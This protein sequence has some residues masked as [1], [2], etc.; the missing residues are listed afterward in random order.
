MICNQTDILTNGLSRNWIKQLQDHFEPARAIHLTILTV[1]CHKFGPIQ[2][3]DESISKR[4]M[5][6]ISTR[7][8]RPPHQGKKPKEQKTLGKYL[9]FFLIERYRIMNNYFYLI[10]QIYLQTRWPWT[11]Y[12]TCMT[13]N[14]T[15]KE[16]ESGTRKFHLRGETRMK[17]EGKKIGRFYES[18]LILRHMKISLFNKNIYKINEICMWN[19]LIFRA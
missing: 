9:F 4:G 11:P 1:D 6:V 15:T 19:F 3:S 14:E 18:K 10:T 12:V 7:I 16:K 5:D 2:I 13:V 8:C 17:C